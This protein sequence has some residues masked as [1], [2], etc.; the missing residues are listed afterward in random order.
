MYQTIKPEDKLGSTCIKVSSSQVSQYLSLYLQRIKR[1]KM[2]ERKPTQTHS[3]TKLIKQDKNKKHSNS[4][5]VP[6]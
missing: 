6:H 1:T 3:C 4:C 5:Y 2:K